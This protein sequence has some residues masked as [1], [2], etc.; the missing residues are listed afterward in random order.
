LRL[1]PKVLAHFGE[2]HPRVCR[3]FELRGPAAACEVFLERIPEPKAKAGRQRPKLELSPFHSVERDFA[4]LLDAEVPAEKLIRAAKGADKVLITKVEVFDAYAG[5]GI[6]PGK[7]SLA[8]SVTLQPTRK[9]LTDPEIEAVAQKIVASVEK[10]TG[11]K[12]RG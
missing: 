2:L 11:G 9:T 8:I 5:K 6:E 4:F 10:A 12:L 3:A 1:G 7:K